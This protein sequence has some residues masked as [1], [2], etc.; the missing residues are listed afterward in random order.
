MLAIAAFWLCP[1]LLLTAAPPGKP[2]WPLTLREGLPATLP[3]YASAP[4][5]SLPDEDE[6]EMGPYT[7]VARFFQRIESATSVKQFR[8]AVQDY[9]SATDLLTP[10]R[11]AFEEARQAGVE[12]RAIE[13]A[14]HKAFVVT[15]RSQGRPTTLVT[16]LATPTRLVL[17]EGANVAGDEAVQLVKAVDFAKVV[18]VKR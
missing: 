18:A 4:T 7:E 15:D 8:L 1:A 5:E 9:G 13:I 12:T 10:L 11:K 2:A 3:G 14:G 6:N 16:V 17:G